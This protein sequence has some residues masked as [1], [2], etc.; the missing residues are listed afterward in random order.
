[1][2][3]RGETVPDPVVSAQDREKEE[4]IEEKDILKFLKEPAHSNIEWVQNNPLEATR[5]TWWLT[6]YAGIEIPGRE[7]ESEAK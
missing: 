3:N 1:M 4:L 2:D 6:G 5:M 7:D